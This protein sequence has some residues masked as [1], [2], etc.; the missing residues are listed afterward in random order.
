MKK[1]YIAALACLVAGAIGLA[2]AYSTEHAKDET[3]NEQALESSS[4]QK[5]Q[6]ADEV[7]ENE[8]RNADLDEAAARV[9]K[10]DSIQNDS[11]KDSSIK[12][13]SGKSTGIND[14]VT[15]DGAD[16]NAGNDGDDNEVADNDTVAKDEDTS[17]E[18][19][20]EVKSQAES[21]GLSFGEASVM[22]WPVQGEVILPFSA[23]QTIYMPTLQQYQYN[24]GLAIEANVNDKVY[25]GAKG[26]ITDV[27][28]NE[29]TGCTV[30]VDLGNGY[31]AIY[32]QLKELNFEKGDTIESGQVIG[33]VS[34]PTKYYAVEGSNVYFAMTKDGEYVDPMTY[35]VAE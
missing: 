26:T 23:E 16:K 33:Y 28:M 27:S 24:Y 34:E 9:G 25:C 19:S 15:E 30:T 35:L 11:T 12:N 32:G 17:V 18:T 8:I 1:Q 6:S 31:S 10:N 29:E 21:N 3:Q 20:A 13:D 2:G 5:Y 7:K 14:G 22:K 4:I